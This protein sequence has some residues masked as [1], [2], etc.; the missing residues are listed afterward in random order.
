[1][2]VSVRF[3]DFW[4]NFNPYNNF[5]TPILQDIGDIA[6]IEEGE[7]DILIFSG[8]GEKHYLFEDCIKIYVTGENDVP[9]FNFCDYAISYHYLELG[10]RHFRIPLNFLTGIASLRN[11]TCMMTSEELLQ[12]DFCS[13]VISNNKCSDPIRIKFWQ[14]LC[15]YKPIASGG[16]YNNNVGGPVVNKLDFIRNFKFNIAFENSIVDGYTTEKILDA[17]RAYSVPIYWGNKMVHKDFNPEAFINIL[18]F[19]SIDNAIKHIIKV[20]NDPVLYL[21]YLRSD[22]LKNYPYEW[23]YG[24]FVAFLK[25]ILTHRK[26]Y[27]PRYGYTKNLLQKQLL[28]NSI[29]G[30][31]LFRKIVYIGLSFWRLTSKI[32]NKVRYIK[33]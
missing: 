27:I 11:S 9:N 23:Y 20:D 14:E 4:D 18:D 17:C 1:M 12:R 15:Q 13:I 25:N 16:M 33:R 5:I 32:S 30:L 26:K 19:D 10:N 7:P 3:V 6:I 2:S 21:Q 24:E 8:F 29:L 22:L 28:Q 31:P